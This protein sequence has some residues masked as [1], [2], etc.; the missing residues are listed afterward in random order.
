MLSC[1]H[2]YH[3]FLVLIFVE[4]FNEMLVFPSLQTIHNMYVNTSD[5]YYID[6]RTRLVNLFLTP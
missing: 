3:F 5:C 6:P 2:L 4:Q 1:T